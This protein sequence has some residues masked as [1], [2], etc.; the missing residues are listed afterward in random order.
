MNLLKKTLLIFALILSNHSISY[1]MQPKIIGGDYSSETYPWMVSLQNN[2]HFCGGV[3]IHQD[4]VLTAS[5]CLASMQASN[6]DVIIG[7]ND[8]INFVGGESRKVDWLVRHPDYDENSFYKDIAIIKLSESSDKTPIKILSNNDAA[9][10]EQNTQLRVLG[11]GLTQEGDANS[12][13][14]FLKQVDLAFQQDG[15]CANTYGVQTNLNY[16]DYSLCA[17]E[18]SGGKDSCLGDS[19]GPLIIK[20]ENTWYAVGL[21]SWGSGCGQPG[22]YGVYNQ[23]S[24]FTDW[25][26][27]RITGVS[28]I[29][30]EK[31]GFLGFE[32]SKSENYRVINNS[33]ENQTIQRH[34]IESSTVSAFERDEA[35]WLLA[36]DIPANYECPF[37][38]NALGGNAGEQNARFHLSQA[39]YETTVL[40]NS[41]VLSKLDIPSANLPWRFFSGTKTA[42]VNPLSEHSEP[43]YGVNEGS[44]G[45]VLSSGNISDSQRSILLTYLT[46]PAMDEHRYLRFDAKVESESPDGLYIFVNEINRNPVAINTDP[47]HVLTQAGG[48]NQWHSYSV[49]LAD[50]FNHIMFIYQKDEAFGKGSDHA[51][52]GNFKLCADNTSSDL[53]CTNIAGDY[54]SE[55]IKNLDDPAPTDTWQDTCKK[56]PKTVGIPNIKLDATSQNKVSIGA[57]SLMY[58]YIGLLLMALVFRQKKP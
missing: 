42:N 48:L 6:I 39:G 47:P 12:S 15:I 49:E 43:W 16:W 20:K 44:R 58:F 8:S 29:G 45:V 2:G 3:L 41:K 17:G 11:W 19:G 22:L 51:L 21:V 18:I 26:N 35:N 23:V 54:F 46:G 13:P 56:L 40:L 5:H 9:L 55:I 7:S 30:P 50:R 52:L 27:Q 33:A 10:I 36:N 38:I 31:I 4:Y 53:S 34:Y 37:T 24:A 25:I 14:V 1:E 32:R 57:G 28:I